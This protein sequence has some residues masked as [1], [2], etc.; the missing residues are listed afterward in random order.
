MESKGTPGPHWDLYYSHD[1]PMLFGVSWGSLKIALPMFEDYS[2]VSEAVI[3][4]EN[5]P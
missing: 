3:T 4:I 1:L 2:P 5:P